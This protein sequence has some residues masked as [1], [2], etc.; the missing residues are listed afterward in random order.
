M[1]DVAAALDLAVVLVV[2][3]DLNAVQYA[4]RRDNL[5]WSHGQQPPVLRKDT[6]AR[7]QVQQ[8]VLGEEGFREVHQIGDGAILGIRPPG[9]ELETVAPAPPGHGAALHR[10]MGMVVACGVAVVFGKCAIGD[11]KQLH[12]LEKPAARPEALYAIAVDLV[13]GLLEL[14]AATLQF[15][16]DQRK[17]VHKHGHIVAVLTLPTLWSILVDDLKTVVV[18]VILVNETDIDHGPV[19]PP[20]GLHMILL[21]QCRPLRDAAVGVGQDTREKPIPLAVA[22]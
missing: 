20:D 14:H 15:N 8:G 12:I 6:V 19:V 11:D 16:V 3:G 4:L 22:E 18:D 7:E 17:A 10:R 2:G 21:N 1:P 5:V 13:E 9:G